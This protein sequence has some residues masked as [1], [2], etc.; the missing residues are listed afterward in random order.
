[1]PEHLVAPLMAK[2]H[3]VALT[4]EGE[5]G[6]SADPLTVYAAHMRDR[7]LGRAGKWL[8]DDLR[9]RFDVDHPGS[10]HT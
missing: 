8:L 4:I 1:M 3:L 5:L 9:T 2:G 10:E 6:R 7:A